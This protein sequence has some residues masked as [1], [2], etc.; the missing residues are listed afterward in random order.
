M[1]SEMCI[2][3]RDY[4]LPFW[5]ML[6]TNLIFPFFVLMNS[7]YKRVPIFIVM[8]GIIILIGHYMDVY[9]MI[10]PATVI[11]RYGFGIAEFSSILIF[12]G[13]FLLIVFYA[14]SKE[15][16][17]AKRNPLIKESENFHY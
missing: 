10:M 11:D 7:D 3:D 13:L 16:L 15:E 2:R 5:G 4:P 8:A 14:L 17:L 9:M 1:G 12:L 6:V